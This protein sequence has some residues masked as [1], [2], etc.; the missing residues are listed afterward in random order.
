MEEDGWNLPFFQPSTETWTPAAIISPPSGT[1]IPMGKYFILFYLIQ[2]KTLIYWI[3]I[4]I[5]ATFFLS[6]IYFC[7]YYI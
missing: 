4:I 2:Y 6:F 5:I 1:L 3:I 7:V